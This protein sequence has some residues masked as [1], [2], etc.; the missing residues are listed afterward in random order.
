LPNEQNL[1]PWKPGESGNPAGINQYTYRTRAEQDLEEW[2]REFGR[3]LVRKIANEAKAGKPWAAKLILD[4]VLPAVTKH[5]L[6]IPGADPIGL[7][8]ALAAESKRKRSNG[9]DLE[10]DAPADGGGS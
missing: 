2:C 4:R 1:R 10:A 5:E 3:D 8:D 9:H 6:E 7:F